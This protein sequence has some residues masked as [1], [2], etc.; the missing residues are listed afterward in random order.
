MDI[1]VFIEDI[2]YIIACNT[3]Q[4]TFNATPPDRLDLT[5]YQRARHQA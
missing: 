5:G 2:L 3:N 1:L 4:N